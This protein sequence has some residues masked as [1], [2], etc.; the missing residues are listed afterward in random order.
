MPALFGLV[1]PSGVVPGGG[2]G[3]M[4][5]GVRALVSVVEQRDMIVFSFS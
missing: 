1:T 4:L 3:L 5:A 2:N